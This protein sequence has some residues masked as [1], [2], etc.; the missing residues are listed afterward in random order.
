MMYGNLIRSQLTDR[1][2]TYFL[3]MQKCSNLGNDKHKM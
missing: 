3:Y 1:P 2:Y